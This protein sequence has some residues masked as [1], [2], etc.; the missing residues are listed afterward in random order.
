MVV[1]VVCGLSATIAIFEP[2]RAFRSVDFPAL[3][4]PRMETKPE[5]K[6][7]A[8]WFRVSSLMR[9]SLPALDTHL[10]DAQFI[11]RQHIDTDPVALHGFSGL[12]HAPQPLGYQATHGGGF[13]LPLGPELQHAGEAREIEVARD[14]VA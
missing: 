14:D 2:T 5:R 10:L 8:G 4:R 13:N 9:H 7:A 1:R 11:A 12:G 3:G 6:P